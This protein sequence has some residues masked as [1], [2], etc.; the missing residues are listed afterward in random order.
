MLL[1]A[2]LGYFGTALVDALWK[3]CSE[4]VCA[5][6]GPLWWMCC[7]TQDHSGTTLG[8]LWWMCCG[9]KFL[10]S[11][12]PSPNNG[13][14]NS[15]ANSKILAAPWQLWL[16]L[17]GAGVLHDLSSIANAVNIVRIPMNLRDYLSAGPRWFGSDWQSLAWWLKV[18]GFE[19]MSRTKGHTKPS[20]RMSKGVPPKNFTF[21]R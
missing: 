15:S 7:A 3:G 20:K 18:L 17:A 2:T 12:N 16:L 4:L 1:K 10:T 11:S 9:L 13:W 21:A 5:T 19:P 8:P 6:L 14:G